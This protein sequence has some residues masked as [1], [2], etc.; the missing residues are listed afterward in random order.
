MHIPLDTL[1]RATL[2][3][4]QGTAWAPTIRAIA[5]Y[6]PGTIACVGGSSEPHA[7]QAH[8]AKDQHSRC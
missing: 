2:I 4:I 3:D 6:A 8:A 5:A 7:A 1:V